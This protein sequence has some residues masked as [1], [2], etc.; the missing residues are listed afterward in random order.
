MK[1]QD[2]YPLLREDQTVTVCNYE[3]WDELARYDGRNSIPAKYNRYKVV[4]LFAGADYD[5]RVYVTEGK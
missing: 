5:L 3:T 2:L 1:L 4:E